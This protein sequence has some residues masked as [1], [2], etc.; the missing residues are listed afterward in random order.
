MPGASVG[1][2][3]DVRRTHPEP[4]VGTVVYLAPF[5]RRLLRILVRTLLGLVLLLLLTYLFRRPLFE[6]LI[7]ERVE[8]LL[9]EQLGGRYSIAALEGSWIFDVAVVGLR[10][11]EPPATGALTRLEFG[12]A[13]VT[14][15]LRKFL[16]DDPLDAIGSIRVSNARVDVDLARPSE[17]PSEP[18][19]NVLEQIPPRLPEVEVA[20][21]VL[22]RTPEGDVSLDGIALALVDDD[23]ADL[24]LGSLKV[25][26]RYGPG[27]RLAGRL[28]RRG[29]EAVT[30][31]SETEL[32]GIVPARVAYAG[33]TV[34]ATLRVG[35]APVELRAGPDS[36][37]AKLENLDTTKLPP[38]IL[39]LAGLEDPLAARVNASVDAR[40]EPLRATYTVGVADLKWRDVAI[41]SADAEGEVAQ[42]RITVKTARVVSRDVTLDARNVAIEPERPYFVAGA[43]RLDLS[44]PDLRPFVSGLDRAL[45]VTVRARTS[46]GATLVV[47]EMRFSGEGLDVRAEGRANLA[48]DP[49]RWRTTEVDGTFEGTL[50]DFRHPEYRFDGEVKASGRVSGTLG[51]PVA[52]AELGGRGLV[53]EGKPVETLSVAG[54]V[55]WPT[56]KLEELRVESEAGSLTA[57]GEVDLDAGEVREAR[58]TVDIRDLRAFLALVPGAPEAEGT[59]AGSGEARYDKEEGLRGF[60]ALSVRGLVY[61]KEKLGGVTFRARAVQN[62]I[63]FETLTAEGA[64]GKADGRGVVWIDRDEAR[65]D[66]LT[67]DARG[68]TASLQAPVALTWTGGVIEATNLDVAALGGRISGRARWNGREL[69]AVLQGREIDL[70]RLDPNVRGRATFLLNAEQGR[71]ALEITAPAIDVEGYRGEI[72]V[73]AAQRDGGIVLERLTIDA[74]KALTVEGDAIL[75]WRFDGERFVYVEGVLPS[76]SLD[77]RVRDVERYTG[78]PAA[79]AVVSLKGDGVGLAGNAVVTDLQPHEAFTLKGATTIDVA[80]GREG[81]RASLQVERSELGKA[82][83]TI[84]SDRGLDWTRVEEWEAFLERAR[85]EGE[86]DAALPDLEPL[87]RFVQGVVYLEGAGKVALALQGPL[88]A[89]EVNGN[90]ELEGVDC[91]LAG[92]LP[93]L[94]E[95]RGVLRIEGR[96]ARIESLQALLGYAPVEVKGT[97]TLPAEGDPEFDVAVKGENVL[98][99]REQYLRLRADLDL[100]LQGALG[101]LEAKGRV[102]LTDA[103][104]SRPMN[105]FSSGAATADRAFQLFSVRDGPLSKLRF[106]VR[107][108]ADR[109]LRISNNVIRGALSLDLELKGT[110]A[111]PEPRGSIFF[112]D[113]LVKLPLTSVKVDQG[114][115]AFPPDS[116]FAPKLNATAHTRLKGYDL[117]A[118]VSGQLPE[119]EVFVS[120]RP[121]LPQ[122]DAL[123][124]L[125]TGRTRAQLEKEGMGRAALT[126]LGSY[127]GESL[128]AEISGPSDPDERTFFDRF[129]FA[130]GREISRSGQETIEG[131][132]EVT[133]RWYLRG[134]RDRFDDYNFGVVWRL[135]FR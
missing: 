74:G 38:W 31:T 129:D 18:S 87:Q 29:P 53:V 112:Q 22:L 81:V 115:L 49:E 14:Y 117:T 90:V 15:D 54:E 73:K 82:S 46:D 3:G 11:E 69:D 130:I 125:T 75:P 116:P 2:D 44:V 134:E 45:A 58:Y 122:D 135:R 83:G 23:T 101:A 36:A 79:G 26:P 63:T 37:T 48:S 89:P 108:E 132:F 66:A 57:Q 40:L 105:L 59:V 123:L 39:D 106:D 19:G 104:Y 97:V 126:S 21:S 128:I 4:R 119:V 12:R 41:E 13:E 52:R 76:L 88:R 42:D 8:G 118:R 80:A 28:R 78:L 95:G 77:A 67:V 5:V 43:E 60:A 98:L 102:V 51:E 27:G 120:T 9:A 85:V 96:T 113:A 70:E 86:V 62:E 121:S 124:L 24:D 107:I 110:G 32:S 68:R 71:I 10:T 55:R 25:P 100:T 114:E 56:A 61:D 64:W 47:E 7:I 133:E 65:I 99:V 1:L 109:S 111:V 50:K 127:L 34:E 72:F 35:G 93:P 84:A 16:G 103:L 92:D 30:W 94:Q 20:G 17:E 6:G 131:E 33:E 91:K